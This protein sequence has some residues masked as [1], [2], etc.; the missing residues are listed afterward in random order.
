MSTPEAVPYSPRSVA[1]AARI[2]ARL[3]VGCAHLLATQPPAR[4]RA[5][6]T[7][8]KR[9][10]RPA[11]YAEADTA[12]RT[13]MAVSLSAGGRKGCLPRS[14]ATVLLCRMRGQWPTWCVGVRTRP[15]FAAHAWIEAEGSLV[16][17]DCPADY[18]QRFFA[19]E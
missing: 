16:G 7:R 13:V 6:L 17:E 11:T 10:A 15:P 2:A 18:F 5:I 9:G 3:A 8:I 19:V 12:L 4:L 14:L 1:P